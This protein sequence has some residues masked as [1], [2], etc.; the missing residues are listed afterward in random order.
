V[1]DVW[2]GACH[3]RYFAVNVQASQPA[4]IC[5]VGHQHT[6]SG[7]AVI[8]RIE[9]SAAVPARASRTDHPI[10]GAPGFCRVALR[11]ALGTELPR[12]TPGGRGC[13]PS[14]RSTAAAPLFPPSKSPEPSLGHQLA[15]VWQGPK[16]QRASNR[17][18]C[19]SFRWHNVGYLRFFTE[20]GVSSPRYSRN[21]VR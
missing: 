17:L 19:A 4:R 16:R 5:A 1:A 9:S 3:E 14:L 12:S 6:L 15:A 10:R 2:S 18:H 11:G 7:R 21:R 8:G 20:E 13:N